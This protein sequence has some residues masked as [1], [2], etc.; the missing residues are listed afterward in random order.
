MDHERNHIISIYRASLA[1]AGVLDQRRQPFA[2]PSAP[3]HLALHRTV[4]C[5]QEIRVDHSLTSEVQWGM[6]R[7]S[8]FLDPLSI[9][10]TRRRKR[11]NLLLNRGSQLSS[12]VISVAKIGS[13]TILFFYAALTGSWAGAVGSLIWTRLLA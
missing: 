1:T 9:V 6:M 7:R 13:A 4:S 5:E 10:G 3:R 12:V 11:K 2:I 8:A